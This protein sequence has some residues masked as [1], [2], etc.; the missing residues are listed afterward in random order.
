[1]LLA[2]AYILTYT[3]T[4]RGRHKLIQLGFRDTNWFTPNIICVFFT[5][6]CISALSK[7][8]Y[9]RRIWTLIYPK[10]MSA[11]TYP[12]NNPKTYLIK[13]NINIY[14]PKKYFNTLLPKN[15]LNRFKKSGKWSYTMT[16][17]LR[18]AK[19][20]LVRI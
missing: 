9:P 13:K 2:G 10:R 8:S 18:D 15:A 14:L 17:L 4:F 3:A 20:Y 11:L 1:M 7:L 5:V 6:L 16:K 12:K 19:W